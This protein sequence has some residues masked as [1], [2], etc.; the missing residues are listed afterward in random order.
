MSFYPKFRRGDIISNDEL[1]AEFKCSSTG[2]MRRSKRTNS[3]VLVSDIKSKKKIY[4]DRW[5]GNTLH[6]TGQGLSGD[7]H[8]HSQ[9][10]KT[11]FS[12]KD[13]EV[14]VFLFEKLEPN[15]YLFQGE[16]ELSDDPYQEKQDD[17]D[18]KSRTVWIFPI[19]LKRGDPVPTPAK[20]ILER[21]EES[22]NNVKIISDEALNEKLANERE[23]NHSGKPSSR[24]TTTTVYDRSP[25][26]VEYCNRRANGIC[27]LCSKPAPFNK[28]KTGAPF[29]ECHHIKWLSKDG[30]DTT[31][32]AVALCPNCHRKMHSLNLKSD[33]EKLLEKA[34]G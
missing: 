30:K 27:E 34:K 23:N 18:D 21:R 3:L 6:Y 11:L 31:D 24:S 12:H 20:T 32:N 26:V 16:A 2:G 1:C 8:I 22:E 4:Y 29:L 25:Y 28:K 7:Q 33:Q 14:S 13:L 10:N 19:E 5:N 9:Q 15:K 17:K